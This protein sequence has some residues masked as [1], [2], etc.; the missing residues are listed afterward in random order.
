MGKDSKKTFSAL[1]RWNSVM[2]KEEEMLPRDKYTMFDKKVKNYR[3]GI[4][5]QSPVLCSAW[6]VYMRPDMRHANGCMDSLFRM[7]WLSVR[8]IARRIV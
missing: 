4:H 3:K 8:L 6:L 2:P 7:A 5:S 1:A